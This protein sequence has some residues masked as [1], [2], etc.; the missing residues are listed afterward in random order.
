MST[1][2]K[3]EEIFDLRGKVVLLTGAIG[4]IGSVLAIAY[5]NYLFWSSQYSY[6]SLAL[7]L[8]MLVLLLGLFRGRRNASLGSARDRSTRGSPSPATVL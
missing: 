5:P 1:G 4:G 8:A 6:E 2:E 7:P 3:L